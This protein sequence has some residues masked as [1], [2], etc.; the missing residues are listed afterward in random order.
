MD[1]SGREEKGIK[2][3]SH[4]WSEK[5]G[6]KEAGEKKALKGK[7]RSC[8]L[9]VLSYRYLLDIW[10][11]YLD[12]CRTSLRGEVRVRNKVCESATLH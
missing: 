4:F 3:N 1:A 9:D 6:K 12:I 11:R 5:P 10:S 8:V 7:T 2:D